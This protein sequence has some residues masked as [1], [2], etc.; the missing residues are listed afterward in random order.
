MLPSGFQAVAY[1]ITTNGRY[2]KIQIA[3]L[4]TYSFW[5]SRFEQE[6]GNLDCNQFLGDSSVVSL[7]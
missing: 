2:V 5:L 7:G 3:G 1:V 4:H 6:A